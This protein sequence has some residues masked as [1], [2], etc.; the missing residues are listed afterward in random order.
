MLAKSNRSSLFT[1]LSLC[2]DSRQFD[3]MYIDST[4]VCM[5]IYDGITNSIYTCLYLPHTKYKPVLNV[6][7]Y[8]YIVGKL[9]FPPFV[10][11]MLF[12]SVC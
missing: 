8:T 4:V 11:F 6:Y 5:S 1:L 7:I 10:P 3:N 9:I 2:I 12:S